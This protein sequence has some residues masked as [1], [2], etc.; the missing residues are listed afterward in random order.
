M[1]LHTPTKELFDSLPG[2]SVLLDVDAPLFT[3]LAVTDGYVQA[4]RVGRSALVGRGLFESFPNNPNDPDA[5]GE[6]DVR[7]SLEAVL[8][9]KKEH[10]LPVQRY[11]L[12][13]DEGMYV[14]QYWSTL[15][16]PVLNS[17]GSVMYIIHTVTNITSEV[18]GSRMKERVKSM[19]QVNNLF[20]ETPIAIAILKGEDF[21]V[22]LAN[23]SLVEV[24]GKGP[25][26]IGKPIREILPEIENQ[27]FIALMQKVVR[28]NKAFQAYEMPVELVR[29]GKQE[30]V[31]FNF[32]YQPYHEPPHPDPQGILIFASDVTTEVA[33]RKVLALTE[34]S[35][36]LAVEIGELGVYEIELTDPDLI[37][38]P[39]TFSGRFADWFRA[40]PKGSLFGSI[41]AAI[42]PDDVQKTLVELRESVAGA[43]QGKHE[44]I[45]RVGSDDSSFR[46]LRSIGQVRFENQKAVTM[47]G[48]V[49]DVTEQV[50]YTQ[51]LRQSE[52]RIKNIV[53]TSPFPIGVY[54]GREMRIAFAN[55]A[56]IDIYGKGDDVIGKCYAD[57][58]PEL[59]HEPVYQQLQSVY[60]TGEPF[61]GSTQRFDIVVNGQLKT[62]YFNYSFFPLRDS[63]GNVYGVLNTGADVTDI[64]LAKQKVEESERTFRNLVE[65]TPVAID[66]MMGPDFVFELVNP[67]MV[68][69][70]G[71][72]KDELMHKPVFEAMPE[73]SNNGLKQILTE[74]YQSGKGYEGQEYELTLLRNGS[75]QSVFVNFIYEPLTNAANEV[76]G[77]IAAAVDVTEQVLSRKKIE[78]SEARFQTLVRDAHTAIVVLTGIDMKVEVVN[79]AYGKLI[80]RRPD[81]LLNKKLFDIIP[82]A[83]EYYLPLLRRVFETGESVHLY[84]SPYVINADG[85][86][87]EGFL[88][89][90]YQAYKDIDGNIVG[91][92]AILQDVTEQVKSKRRLEENERHLELL[93]NTVPAMIF[94]LDEQQRYRSYNETFMQWFN[95]DKHQ[96]IGKTVQEFLGE[97]AYQRVEPHLSVAYSGQQERYEM[98]SPS[99]LGEQQWLNIVYTPHIDADG[100]VQGVIVHATDVTERKL[101]QQKIEDEVIMRTKE[102]AEANKALADANRELKRS[103]QNLEE[104]AHAASHDLKEPIRKIH[105]FTNQLKDQLSNHLS[106]AERRSFTRIESATQRMG[107]LIDDLL[108]Y[109]HVSQRPHEKEPVNLNMSIQNVLEDLELDIQEK[110][111]KINISD[112]PVV[113]GYRRQVQQ[114][115]QNLLSNAIKYSRDEVQPE[116]DISCRTITDENGRFYQV[117]VKDNGIGIHPEYR[118]KI[119]HM[120]TRLHGRNEY[121]G[122]GVGLSIVKK[123]VENHDGRIQVDSKEGEGSTFHIFLPAN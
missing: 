34:K 7:R 45:Y 24:W 6:Q 5:T 88:N 28:E 2:N 108:L 87:I 115:F 118:E 67:R 3:V 85:S 42:H 101:A 122:T 111:A 19:E 116:I 51:T 18:T 98:R 58:L 1:P 70:I 62:S 15:N 103:N 80:G 33:T 104:F 12:P 93:S 47:S 112:L 74:V 60:T 94:Y 78:E 117:M 99:R 55:Q 79:E 21:R 39:A 20:M 105:F 40:E 57:V 83:G 81:E 77:I 107:A 13:D 82:E 50:N 41:L 32:S 27:G 100:K 95:V 86:I 92:M 68:E 69:L 72:P 114:L 38:C 96:A 31:Y 119:F 54:I 25:D 14:E 29:N 91:V 48:I 97:A 110:N 113:Q 17:D 23:Q 89:V 106:E 90:V 56:I 44:I 52:E 120:F 10:R 59:A 4:A 30:R 26:L 36:E 102:L 65:Q 75:V 64:V 8:S 61:F 9:D 66:I 71:R 109:S 76:I 37:N 35:L 16:K 73:I 123:I 63:S 22:E 11:D 46:Y 53:E 84:D 49:Q 43:N 121:S